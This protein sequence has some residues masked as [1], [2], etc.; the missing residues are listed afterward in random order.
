MSTNAHKI[1]EMRNRPNLDDTSLET[2]LSWLAVDLARAL[3][4]EAEARDYWFDHDGEAAYATCKV[5]TTSARSPFVLSWGAVLALKAIED[6]PPTVT[7]T[8]FLFSDGDRLGRF[9]HYGSDFL[10]MTWDEAGWSAPVWLGD[11][12][13]EWESITQACG[14]AS[15]ASELVGQQI[16]YGAS[17]TGTQL[18]E[19]P[20]AISWT[21]STV[22]GA[23][24]EGRVILS[25]LGERVGRLIDGG[26]SYIAVTRL[27]GSDWLV[28]GWRAEDASTEA[29]QG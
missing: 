13:G 16:A 1:L 3:D 21:F 22:S 9:M 24:D 5:T 25:A 18:P 17:I 19:G 7:A 23:A 28:E 26:R 11:E 6:G 12:F 14:V 2:A 15:S 8:V 20:F 10:H 4:Q 27:P 29:N